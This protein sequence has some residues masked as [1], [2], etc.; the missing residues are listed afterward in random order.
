MITAVLEQDV[1]A[2][3]ITVFEWVNDFVGSHVECTDIGEDITYEVAL[4]GRTGE[5]VV[6]VQC[7][8]GMSARTLVPSDDGRAL[9]TTARRHGLRAREVAGIVRG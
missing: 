7:A 5:C 2:A 3:A 8:C 4:T 9:I 6:L 1:A